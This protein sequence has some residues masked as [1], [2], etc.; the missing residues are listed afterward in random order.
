MEVIAKVIKK[1]KF[2]IP[3]EVGIQFFSIDCENFWIPVFTG[4]TTFAITSMV[5]SWKTTLFFL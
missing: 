5:F 4:M 2:V 1:E 3:T